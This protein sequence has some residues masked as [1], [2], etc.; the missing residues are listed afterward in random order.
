MSTVHHFNEVL[1]RLN[2]HLPIEDDLLRE[3]FFEVLNNPDTVTRYIQLASLLRSL[4]PIA[5][6]S[7]IVTLLKV[8]QQ[9]DH[10]EERKVQIA[11]STGKKVIGVAGS[12]KKGFKTINISTPSCLVAATAG[13]YI[14]KNV[15]H[16]TSS[17]LGSSD[18]LAYVGANLQTPVS[19]MV[20]ILKETGFGAFSIENLAPKFDNIYGGLFGAP[21]VL[22][23][24]LAAALSPFA[25]D[26]ILY[27]LSHPN[28]LLSAE[29]LCGIGIQNGLVVASSSD[30][31]HYID[32]M[33]S[34]GESYISEFKVQLVVDKSSIFNAQ[35]RLSLPSYSMNQLREGKTYEAHVHDILRV[36]IGKGDKAQEDTIALNA[37]AILYLSGIVSTIEKGYFVAKSVIKEGAAFVKLRSFIKQTGGNVE[38]LDSIQKITYHESYYISKAKTA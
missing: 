19:E 6:A 34:I 7:N 12:G 16:S 13:A 5:S 38:K 27:G 2:V 10:I 37:G 17:Y 15:S 1:Y 33:C 3:A 18:F 9:L 14:A 20:D 21:H 30:G 32:E 24:G 8:A 22:S 29:V 36:L 35:E 4:M 23:F 25:Y 26:H 11:L 31:I 28:T